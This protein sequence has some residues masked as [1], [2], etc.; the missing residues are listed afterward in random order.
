VA[1]IDALN[2]ELTDVEK[3]FTALTSSDLPSLNDK[4]KAKSLPP[5][6]VAAAAT[7]VDSTV[8]AGGPL[9]AL[10]SGLVGGRYTGA[11]S[12]LRESTKDER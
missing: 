3:S 2:H 10:F 7:P 12:A 6:A 8:A 1:R 9:K 11:T 5:I 4:L